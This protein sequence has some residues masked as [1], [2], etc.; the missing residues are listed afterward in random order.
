M[1]ANDTE[2]FD[3]SGRGSPAASL[4]GLVVVQ[5]SVTSAVQW[6]LDH[7]DPDDP[8][9]HWGTPAVA[10]AIADGDARCRMWCMHYVAV[11]AEHAP[12]VAYKELETITAGLSD[13]DP[14]VRTYAFTA[15]GRIAKAVAAVGREHIPDAVAALEDPHGAVRKCA[16]GVLGDTAEVYDAAVI[17][18]APASPRG[19]PTTMRACGTTPRSRCSRRGGPIPRR[20]VRRPTGCSRRSTIRTTAC[21]RTCACCWATSGPRRG[22][23]GW[24]RSP[25]VIPTST[26][27]RRRGG[28]SGA[29]GGEARCAGG[30]R[31]ARCALTASRRRGDHRDRGRSYFRPAAVPH[32]VVMKVPCGVFP[33]TPELLTW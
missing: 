29:W 31:S 20:C 30:H 28:R 14:D 19:W 12:D 25:T 8:E 1:A 10:A 17:A 22:A 9:L 24:R 11:V 4:A 16:M 21:G 6:L 18:H 7:F 32:V 23:S 27:A 33:P 15:L 13:P 5:G 3:P 26:S 2:A